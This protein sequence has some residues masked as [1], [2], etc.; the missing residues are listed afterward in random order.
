MTKIVQICKIVKSTFDLGFNVIVLGDE[1]PLS[2]ALLIALLNCLLSNSESTLLYLVLRLPEEP[3]L[4]CLLV[5]LQHILLAA[6]QLTEWDQVQVLLMALLLV[7]G[8]LAIAR[9]V[10]VELIDVLSNVL[11]DQPRRVQLLTVVL[12]VV[13]T[14]E[15]L[16]LEDDELLSLVVDLLAVTEAELKLLILEGFDSPLLRFSLLLLLDD[17]RL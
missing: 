12:Q 13:M 11:V 9:P 10:L 16:L 8:Y 5:T 14:D 1:R 17:V 3:I 2:I 15:L 4:V 6:C 7:V